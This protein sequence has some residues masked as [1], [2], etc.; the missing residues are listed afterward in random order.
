MKKTV[1]IGAIAGLVVAVT[2][3]KTTEANYRAAYEI[4]K[5]KQMDGGDST[6]TAG[7]KNEQ[8]PRMTVFSGVKLP[9]RTEPLNLTKD[10]GGDPSTFKVYNVVAASFKQLF[11]AN[12]FRDRLKQQGFDSFLVHNR[13]RTYFVVALTTQS[14]AEAAE[15]LERLKGLDGV[16]MKAPFPY[17]L[18]AAQLV[19]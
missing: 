16:V 6:V 14:P 9:I 7:L 17:V 13:Q 12:S 2:G 8:L 19:R 15:A 11:N 1:V 3:C 18:R 5:E 10:G 4:A